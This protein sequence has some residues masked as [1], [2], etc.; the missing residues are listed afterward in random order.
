MNFDIYFSC[1]IIHSCVLAILSFFYGFRIICITVSLISMRSRSVPSRPTPDNP[2][3]LYF[4]SIFSPSSKVHIQVTILP[5]NSVWVAALL[6]SQSHSAIRLRCTYWSVDP[7]S[8][9]EACHFFSL[10]SICSTTDMHKI[11]WCVLKMI[12]LFC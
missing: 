5:G 12:R 1:Y 2:F 11:T 3:C 10:F 4:H 9:Q 8:L 6:I 7:S